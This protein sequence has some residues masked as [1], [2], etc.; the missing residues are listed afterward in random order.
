MGSRSSGGMQGA[1]GHSTPPSSRN[2][3]RG[4]QYTRDR[5]ERVHCQLVY[6]QC[7]SRNTTNPSWNA[8]DTVLSTVLFCLGGDS[9]LRWKSGICAPGPAPAMRHMA[10]MYASTTP[11]DDRCSSTKPAITRLVD[12][13]LH[14]RG[15]RKSSTRPQGSWLHR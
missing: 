15:P 13:M 10:A 3:A 5:V 9:S 12:H 2:T 11:R 8:P 6:S 14:T 4:T 1:S 7:H